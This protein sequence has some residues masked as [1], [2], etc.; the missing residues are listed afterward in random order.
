MKG[1]TTHGA[2]F[3]RVS[4]PA[5]VTK[6]ADTWLDVGKPRTPHPVAPAMRRPREFGTATVFTG[7][8]PGRRVTGSIGKQPALLDMEPVTQRWPS[9][10]V[11]SRSRSPVNWMRVVGPASVTVAGP[12]GVQAT[13]KVSTLAGPTSPRLT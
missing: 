13:R 1:G 6:N 12:P 3:V 8:A 2:A 11:T 7:F 10:V 5:P 4:T 9:F